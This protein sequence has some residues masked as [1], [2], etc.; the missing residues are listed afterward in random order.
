M[1]GKWLRAAWIRISAAAAA[2]FRDST[3][4]V[5]GTVTSLKSW[6]DN[7]C[8]SL[9]STTMPADSIGASASGAPPDGA[10]P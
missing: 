4:S 7:P 2:T 8:A 10:A 5:S 1:I 3:P 6:R 9:P